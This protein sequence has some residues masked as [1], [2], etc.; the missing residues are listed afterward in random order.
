MAGKN[1]IRSIRF[2]DELYELIDRQEGYDAIGISTAG[3]VNPDTGSIKRSSLVML[4]PPGTEY[5]LY[6]DAADSEGEAGCVA[7]YIPE[8]KSPVIEYDGSDEGLA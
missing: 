8:M 6:C 1:N 5:E 4:H 3:Q 7:A 2:T